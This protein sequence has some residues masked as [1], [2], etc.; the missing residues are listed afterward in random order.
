MIEAPLRVALIS[1]HASPLA[2][3]GGIDAGGQNVYVAHVAAALARRGHHVD[4]LTRRDSR[5]LPTAVDMRPGVRVLHIDAG[6]PEFVPK[7]QLL[8]HMRAF[9]TAAL[10]LMRRSLRHDAVHANFFMSGLVGLRL[11]RQ[12]N[13][14]LVQTFH[15]L[16]AV[17]RLHQKEADRFPPERIELESRIAREADCV[18]AECPQDAADLIEHCGA[19]PDRIAQ[20]PCGV[21]LDEFGPGDKLQ[22]RRKLHLPEDEFIVLQL[23]RLVPRKG[24]DNV[25]RAVAAMQRMPERRAF[26]LLIVG[27][28]STVPDETRT[29]EIGRLRRI[30]QEAG[31]DAR[32]T[33]VGRRDRDQLR[34]YYRAADVFVTTPWYE[35]F[36]ITPLEAMACATPVI[37]AAVGGIQHTVV[38]GLTGYLVP[39]Q[40][41]ETL[42]LRLDD[43]RRHPEIGRLMGR[44]GLLRVQREFTWDS[45][46]FRLA[47]IYAQVA[48]RRAMLGAQPIRLLEPALDAAAGAEAMPLRHLSRPHLATVA[49][50]VD[51]SVVPMP[52]QTSGAQG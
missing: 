41:P 32:V 33:F 9:G 29:P 39:A 22:A 44:A 51:G 49:E 15:A 23:G 46:A 20:V 25:I 27:G 17:R 34:D 26:R 7:E 18:V 47:G 11:Q 19:S 37:G 36:G 48:A 6:P 40:D 45:V 4:V 50:S 8:P 21:D 30:A 42:A 3:Q 16:G 2:Q 14:P 12:L 28:E 24:V 52:L 31:V 5:A 13:L 38:D 43:L 1:E 10:R 35:P